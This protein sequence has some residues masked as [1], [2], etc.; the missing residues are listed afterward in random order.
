MKRSLV[1][2]GQLS[3]FGE[4]DLQALSL[5]AEKAATETVA[6][7]PTVP[8]VTLHKQGKRLLIRPDNAMSAAIWA[9]VKDRLASA[10][11]QTT[12]YY[13]S[14]KEAQSLGPNPTGPIR[15]HEQ[16]EAGVDKHPLFAML[17]SYGV[18]VKL[19]PSLAGWVKKAIRKY[20]IERAPFPSQAITSQLKL[21]DTLI[22]GMVLKCI[23]TATFN[24][25]KFEAG[26]RYWVSKVE[27]GVP[28]IYDE[29]VTSRATVKLDE[30]S[31]NYRWAGNIAG[32][33]TY[34]EDSDKCDV[35][36]TLRDLFPEKV[37]YWEN[38]LRALGF[39]PSS[40]GGVLYRTGF[41]DAACECL[42]S[43]W[44]NTKEM[45]MGKTSET[46]GAI[47]ARGKQKIAWVGPINANVESLNEFDRCGVH[48]YVLVEK[49]SDLYEPD[50]TRL[51]S[52]KRYFLMSY[53]F[54]KNVRDPEGKARNRHK[55]EDRVTWLSPREDRKCPHCNQTMQRPVVR[56]NADTGKKYISEWVSTYGYVC[57][58][59][60]CEPITDNRQ[61]NG[62]RGAAWAVKGNK[63]TRHRKGTYVDQ[64]FKWHFEHCMKPVGTGENGWQQ[65]GRQCKTCGQ[66]DATWK[67]PLYK[68]LKKLFTTAVLDELHTVKSGDSLAANAGM[69]FMADLRI[70]LTGTLLSNSSMDAYWP[71]HWIFRGPSLLFNYERD[72][73]ERKYK[74]DFCEELF[75]QSSV[76]KNGRTKT[77]PFLKNPP[78]FWRLMAPLMVRR[79]YNDPVFQQALR[80]AQLFMPTIDPQKVQCNMSKEQAMLLLSSIKDFEKKF[81]DIEAEAEEKGHSLNGTLVMSQMNLMRIAA[82]VPDMLN[83]KFPGVYTG[84]EGGG[85]VTDLLNLMPE[86]TA[87]GKKVIILCG[88]RKMQTILEK[89]L[90]PYNP[91]R[92]K[93]GKGKQ[94][95]EFF[96]TFR[97][98]PTK[99]VAIA[100]TKAIREG[101]DLACADAVICTDLLWEVA[102]QRQA[103]ARVLAP[104]PEP[105]VAK[106]YTLLS[107]YSIDEH[108]DHVFYSKVAGTEQAMDRRVITR[109][110]TDVDMKLFVTRVLEEEEKL[111]NYLREAGE[112]I[113]LLP[114]LDISRFEE[115]EL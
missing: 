79:N 80:E 87:G 3:L 94:R 9:E 28:T 89:L 45:R 67:P 35:G 29:P 5:F 108:I 38:K 100:G 109:K 25:H 40:E 14:T 10:R 83:D 82:T 58:N 57:R 98:D 88:F 111:S 30:Q 59:A 22:E 39:G 68:R 114:Q 44:A 104:R 24:G 74:S 69:S 36:P 51:R 62:K 76:G 64:A 110:A 92:F 75:I 19:S 53:E 106:V 73:G 66:V 63:L 103:I 2:E 6:P 97:N 90:A 8:S 113:V 15:L 18:E 101:V 20:A 84:P 93:G 96:D 26:Q 85:K 27:N 32:V 11:M 50:S 31:K 105:R 54:I 91:I 42:K 78:D 55:K 1:P 43:G 34:F 95:K 37:A 99:L 65:Q 56:T 52:D 61:S 49:L 21:R 17:A 33:E 4:V 70:G 23:K 13:D 107:R 48:D 12:K 115:R 77:L 46:I 81:A 71:L 112:D 16:I 47:E 86:L 60:D 7:E 41:E 72:A 102:F